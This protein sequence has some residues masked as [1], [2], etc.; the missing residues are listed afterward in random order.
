VPRRIPENRLRDLLEAATGVLVGQGYRQTQMADVAAA[1]GV[2][3]G[4]VYLYV[5]SKEALFAACLRHADGEPPALSELDLPLATPAPGELADE[6]KAALAR[7]ASPPALL[8]ALERERADD[9][10]AELEQIVRELFATACR[11]RTAIKLMD[12]SAT[13]HPELAAIFYGGGRFTQVERLTRYLERR[14]AAG[15]LRTVPVAAVAARFVVE[16]ISTWAVH[17]H[18]DPAP[19]AYDPADAEETVV[20]F[21]LGGLIAAPPNSEET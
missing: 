20:Q 10:R 16:T 14:I 5:E 6:L 17:M 7:E 3:K 11:H 2:A 8:A 18:W 13:A 9:V 4:T 1:M 15:Q 12:R 21:L 19:Q